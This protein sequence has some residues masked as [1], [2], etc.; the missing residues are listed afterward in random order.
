[1]CAPYLRK[2]KSPLK[3]SCNSLFVQ[4]TTT[5]HHEDD[6]DYYN[7][8]KS[9]LHLIIRLL[10]PLSLILATVVAVCFGYETAA[11]R[12][13]PRYNNISRQAGLLLLRVY[14]GYRDGRRRRRRR[15]FYVF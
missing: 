12:S 7:F 13:S 3:N 4:T 8:K 5:I 14:E 6:D 10:R 11:T 2:I 15:I 9:F 1:M